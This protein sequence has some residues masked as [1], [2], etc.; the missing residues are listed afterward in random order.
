MIKSLFTKLLGAIGIA[1][2]DQRV[3][4]GVQDVQRLAKTIAETKESV[5]NM[6]DAGVVR[7]E[8]KKEKLDLEIKNLKQLK[9]TLQDA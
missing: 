4:V 7:K 8:G 6:V 2:I 9:K 3:N 1:T 5:S